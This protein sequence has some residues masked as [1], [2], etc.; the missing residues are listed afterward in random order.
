MKISEMMKLFNAAIADIASSEE[1]IGNG[2]QEDNALVFAQIAQ[3]KLL[4]VIAA[5]KVEELRRADIREELEEMRQERQS[6]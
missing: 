4:A 6:R 1:Q 5:A 2:R 3:A